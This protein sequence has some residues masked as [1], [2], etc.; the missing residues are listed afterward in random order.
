MKEIN[1][2]NLLIAGVHFGHRTRF[3]NPKMSKYIYGSNNKIHVINLE[4]TLSALEQ[5]KKKV[6]NITSK[7]GKVLF[8][9]TKHAARNTV[10][11]YA[12]SVNQP[13]VAH[14]WLGGCLTN[15]KTIRGLVNRLADLQS[16]RDDGT[17]GKMIKKE[18]L[19][20]ER[21][22]NKLELNVGGIKDMAGL[23]DALFV[24]DV[25]YERI[26]VREARTLGIP[27]IAVVDTNSS[28]DNIDCV[29]PGNDDATRSIKLYLSAI[30]SACAEGNQAYK[31]ESGGKP[32]IT[33]K[34]VDKIEKSSYDSN[35]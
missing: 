7:G 25:R 28:P 32:S 21:E 4:H 18:A 12:S 6:K 17:F 13:Y 2:R 23:P 1:M 15:Y 11:E 20:F 27:V 14:R 22:I 8:V 10:K 16:K 26:A 29:I 5:A 33:V 3:W 24:I 9:G 30:S 31:P 19:M 35:K 34:S